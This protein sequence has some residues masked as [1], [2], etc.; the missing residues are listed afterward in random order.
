MIVG[1]LVLLTYILSSI[2][3]IAGMGAA[4]VLVP[5]YITLGLG[6]YTAI[7]LALA[8]NVAD[9]AVVT[10]LH[11]RRGLVDWRKVVIVAAP[12]VL[13]IPLGV[14]I[15]VNIPRLFI[16]IAFGF[17]LVF[18]LYRLTGQ[19]RP[20]GGGGWAAAVL[21]AVEGLTAGLIG[22]DAAPI[23]LIAYSY[24]HSNPKRISA[25]TA[26]AAFIV[27]SAAFA[28][29]IY[30]LHS[31]GMPGINMVALASVMAAGAAGGATGAKLVHR[32][33]PLHVKYTMLTVLSVAPAEIAAKIA[34]A[35]PTAM[36]VAAALAAGLAGVLV[37]AARRPVAGVKAAKTVG[38]R[39]ETGR[40]TG[41][42]RSVG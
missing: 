32:V 2:F 16:L 4:G 15:A 7:T 3:A 19:L 36:I 37:R 28:A 10:A 42:S 26:A 12:A 6:V 41:R 40:V 22:M 13:L 30:T 18:T 34:A 8:Q 27:S 17:F 31:I 38:P 33:K 20:R 35:G 9:L 39:A 25:N 14:Y 5:N 21:G 23:A 29:Y 1:V 24:M 11:T